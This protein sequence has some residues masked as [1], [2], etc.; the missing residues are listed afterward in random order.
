MIRKII[1]GILT[2]MVFYMALIKM[3]IL[4]SKRAEKSVAPHPMEEPPHKLYV[5]SFAK[6]NPNGEKEIEIEGDS[7]NILTG[8]VTLVN[9]MAKAYAEETPVTITADNGDYD[10]VAENVHLKKNVVATTRNGTRLLTEELQIHP[11]QKMMETDIEARVKKDNMTIDGTGAQGDSNLKKVKFKKH[12]KVV[13]QGSSP[14]P[15]GSADK[16]KAGSGGGTVITCDG[17]LEIDYEKNIARFKKNVVAVD[18]RGKLL[19]DIMD[20]YYDRATHQVAKIMAA[21]NVVVE[22]RDGN[23]TYSDNVIYLAKE[24]RVIMGGDAEALYFGGAQTD[25]SLFHAPLGNK[26][27]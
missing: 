6:Y 5:F 4:L 9:V 20:V 14:G 27:A 15:P 22:N 2:F 24:G 7:A 23:K 3:Q 18:D 12:V 8:T 13:I 26:T 16:T 11:S 25:E 21:G 19:G 17:P 1:L 10:K